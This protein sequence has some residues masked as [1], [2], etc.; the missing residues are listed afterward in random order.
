MCGGKI[1][2]VTRKSIRQSG[3]FYYP[4]GLFREVIE[5]PAFM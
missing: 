4:Y 5:F 2:T 1:I 3:L